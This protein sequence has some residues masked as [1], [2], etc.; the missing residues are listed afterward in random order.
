LF[1]RH[2][3]ELRR[4]LRHYRVI[5]VVCD[6]ARTHRQERARLVKVGERLLDRRGPERAQPG[7]AA[8]RHD[9]AGVPVRLGRRRGLRL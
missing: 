2:L 6:N 9:A 1:C 7:E 4:A 8:A 5:H 3:V